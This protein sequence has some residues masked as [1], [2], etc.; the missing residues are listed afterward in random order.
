MKLT[1][2]QV[3]HPDIVDRVK[4]L[5]F[6]LR[7]TGATVSLVGARGVMLAVIRTRAPEILEKRFSDGSTFRASD[8]YMRK[9]LHETLHWSQRKATQAAQKRPQDWEDQCER[10]FFR[11]VYTIKEEDIPAFLWVNSDQTQCVYAPGDKMTWAETGSKQV[12]LIGGE[13]KRAFTV[14]VSIASDGT[15]LPMQAIYA[16]KTK[17]S[18]PSATAP[19]Y[20]NLID[21]GFLIQE[22]GTTTYW[23]NMNT[24]KDFVNKILAPYFDKCKVDHNLP[25]SQHS[26]WTIDVWSVH[27]SGEF[28][29]WMKKTHPMIILDYV[30]GGCTSVA[31]PCDVGIQRPFKLSLKR[32]YHEDVVTEVMDQLDSGAAVVDF[33]T[34]IGMLRDRSTR[35]IWN[36]YK[37]INNMNLV[38][39]VRLFLRKNISYDLPS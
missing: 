7:E 35:W 32:S 34:H 29:G 1:T 4:A 15:V 31:Q 8:S 14:M 25:L 22:S 9:W 21:A 23:S 18:R 2:Y 39:K 37:A 20:K 6:S 17:R 38:E 30:P 13:E 28:R 33:D 5:L 12:P 24:M 26:L 11:K 19:N 27:R 16:G 36:A 3:N 10:S